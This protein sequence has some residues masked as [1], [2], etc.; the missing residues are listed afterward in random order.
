M[1]ALFFDKRSP[2]RL[3][4]SGRA[5]AWR[6]ASVVD[7]PRLTRTSVAMGSLGGSVPPPVFDVSVT[8]RA[9]VP[10]TAKVQIGQAVRYKVAAGAG[11]TFHPKC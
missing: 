1:H 5:A 11:T 7:A 6:P 4:L 9:F 3:P 10:A 8:D 2:R